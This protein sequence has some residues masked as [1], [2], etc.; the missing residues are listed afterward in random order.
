VEV[1]NSSKKEDGSLPKAA[2]INSDITRAEILKEGIAEEYY[3]LK[4][5]LERYEIL[6][7]NADKILKNDVEKTVNEIQ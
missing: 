2:E 1:L 6:K 3:H 5:E 7:A 4:R